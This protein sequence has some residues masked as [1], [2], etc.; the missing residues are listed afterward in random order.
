MVLHGLLQTNTDHHGRAATAS[1]GVLLAL[2]QTVSHYK[3]YCNFLI[4][5]GLHSRREGALCPPFSVLCVRFLLTV[6][7]CQSAELQG[8][9]EDSNS[10]ALAHTRIFDLKL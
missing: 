3:Q 9:F 8:T 5:Y 1:C 6:G 2:C 10:P 4:Q 7:K